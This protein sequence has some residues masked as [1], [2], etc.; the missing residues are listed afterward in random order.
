MFAF[1]CKI[2]NSIPDNQ[3]RD[4]IFQVIVSTDIV[5]TLIGL[6]NFVKN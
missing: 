2:E 3:F 4:I 5:N 1:I 6:T